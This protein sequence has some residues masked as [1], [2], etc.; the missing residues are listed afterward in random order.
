[1]WSFLRDLMRTVVRSIWFV[2]ANILAHSLAAKR[3]VLVET[4][5][6]NTW[7]ERRA[8]L[9]LEAKVCGVGTMT[10]CNLC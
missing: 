3:T 7:R 5:P 4:T 9:G 6:A 2:V 1:M 8:S 10:H